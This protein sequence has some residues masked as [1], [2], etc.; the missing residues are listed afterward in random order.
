[1]IDGGDKPHHQS[2]NAFKLFDLVHDMF[3]NGQTIVNQHHDE[4]FIGTIVEFVFD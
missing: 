3:D 1:M 4:R 2:L